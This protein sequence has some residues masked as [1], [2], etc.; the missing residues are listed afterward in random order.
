MA[1]TKKKGLNFISPRGMD[2]LCA[3]LRDASKDDSI[4]VVV[5]TGAG[6]QCFCAGGDLGQTIDFFSKRK[7]L[8]GERDF[9]T[10][11]RLW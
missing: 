6:D 2:E 9:L 3:C 5:L 10:Q 4:G 1:N 7:T 8:A 11:Y